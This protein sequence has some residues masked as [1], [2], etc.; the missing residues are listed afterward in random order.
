MN[1]FELSSKKRWVPY[2]GRAVIHSIMFTTERVVLLYL[3]DYYV[4]SRPIRFELAQRL[5]YGTFVYERTNMCVRMRDK[6]NAIQAWTVY[7]S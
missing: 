1:I 4:C 2:A 3:D 5:R 7:E 6:I